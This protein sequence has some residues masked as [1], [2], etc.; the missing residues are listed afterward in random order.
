MPSKKHAF[1]FVS[2]LGLLLAGTSFLFYTNPVSLT[3]GGTELFFHTGIWPAGD[4]AQ[5]SNAIADGTAVKSNQSVDKS[6]SSVKNPIQSTSIDPYR[7]QKPASGTLPDSL[8]PR[9]DSLISTLKYLTFSPKSDQLELFFNRLNVSAKQR[10]RIW[11]YGDSQIEGDRITSDLR[12]QLQSQ[13][14]GSGMGFIPINNPATYSSIELGQQPDWNKYN[15]FQ[16]RKKT[17]EFGPSGL[18]Y[19]PKDSNPK[20]WN[21]IQINILKSCKYKQLYLELNADSTL[22]VQWK[23]KK[24]SAWHICKTGSHFPHFKMVSI[25]DSALYGSVNIRVKGKQLHV[26]GMFLEGANN[27]VYVDNF[28]IRGHS[29]DGLRILDNSK[30]QSAALHQNAGLIIFHYGNNMVPY[31]KTDSKSE[32]WVKDIFRGIF[33]KYKNSCQQQ[34]FL[35]V[36]P[37]DMGFQKGDQVSCYPSCAVL[38]RWMKEVSMDEGM[39][40][41]DFYQMIQDKGGILKWREQHIAS[42]DGHL[43]P[44][45]QRIFAKE[46]STELLNAYKA[47]KLKNMN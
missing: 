25:G 22:E 41:F 19:I 2:I 10:V 44:T 16:H 24:D 14:G 30:L 37:G 17:Q 11:Y 27:G 29:G 8:A 39:A 31:L 9:F 4:S 40:Y 47:F 28:G 23:R 21:T 1:L 43:G 38:N 13:F 12:K 5:H 34:S 35:V 20:K 46:M 26:Y 15:C 42:L 36:G 7:Y 45:G 33:K 32:K 6:T 18:V 3:L